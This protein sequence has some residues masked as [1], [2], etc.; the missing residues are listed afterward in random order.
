[1]RCLQWLLSGLPV[2]CRNRVTGTGVTDDRRGRFDLAGA[3]CINSLSTRLRSRASQRSPGEVPTD[4][5]VELRQACLTL[6]S[7]EFP[8]GT[9]NPT[10]GVRHDGAGQVGD[11]TRFERG[12]QCVVGLG[13]E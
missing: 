5:V 3:Q 7:R 8:V 12:L 10:A 2:L 6:D 1:M 9:R 13:P 4:Y 11:R